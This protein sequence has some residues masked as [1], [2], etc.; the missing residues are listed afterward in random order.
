MKSVND[1]YRFRE[2]SRRNS[3][4]DLAKPAGTNPFLE[5]VAKYVALR[6]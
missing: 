3:R 2:A 4:P 5:R 1:F 6:S